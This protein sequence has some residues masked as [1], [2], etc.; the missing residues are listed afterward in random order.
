M[1]HGVPGYRSGHGGAG[2][3][4]CQCSSARYSLHLQQPL[5]WNRTRGTHVSVCNGDQ[6]CAHPRQRRVQRGI[7]HE[8]QEAQ[9]RR[10]DAPVARAAALNEELQACAALKQRAHVPCAAASAALNALATRKADTDTPRR[11]RVCPCAQAGVPRASMQGGVCQSKT[12]VR[13]D[14]ADQRPNWH[15]VGMQ[16]CSRNTWGRPCPARPRMSLGA[17]ACEHPPV[18]RAVAAGAAR[19]PDEECARGAQQAADQ[20]QVQVVA[21]RDVRHLPSAHAVGRARQG[22]AGAK[23]PGRA[24]TLTWQTA[25]GHMRIAL[26]VCRVRDSACPWGRQSCCVCRTHSQAH[27]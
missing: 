5:T 27:S 9:A 22:T 1:V 13:C 23:R 12:C 16:S 25:I 21:R 17:H 3:R 15:A 4:S 6:R 11:L 24:A 2:R 18:E 7:H 20:R 19:A 26:H 14:V 8:R 10:A